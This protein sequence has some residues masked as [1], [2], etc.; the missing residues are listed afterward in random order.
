M[1]LFAE[2][3]AKRYSVLLPG[4]D[5]SIPLIFDGKQPNTY[6]VEPASAKAWEGHGFIGD[7]RRGGSCNF[8]KY[9][10]VPHCN[11]TH[12]ECVG[13][14]TTE[15]LSIR[16]LL[17]EELIPAVVVTINPEIAAQTSDSY[18]P[19]F[20]PGD[21]VISAAALSTA[22]AKWDPA[23][24]GALIIRC[25][26]N[27]SEK[28]YYDYSQH[29]APFFSMEAMR[30]IREKG[31]RHLLVDF[32]SLDRMHDEGKLSAH[33]IFWNVAAGTHETPTGDSQFFTVT[34]F[35]FVP[36]EVK[37]GCYLLNLQVAPFE[38]DAAPSRPMVFGLV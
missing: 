29:V 12:T 35:I 30:L 17:K 21:K 15:R 36:D 37:D 6:G 7:T 28:M 25:L 4:K 11:G 24:F 20:A 22:F 32:P 3:G 5:L 18:D 1:Q 19:A 38:S 13:H 14:I 10:L 34:E 9:T 31:F 8:E 26:P 27:A 2:I 23:F 33:H 16:Q